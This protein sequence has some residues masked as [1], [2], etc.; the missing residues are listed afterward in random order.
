MLRSHSDA[1]VQYT[2]VSRNVVTLV[3]LVSQRKACAGRSTPFRAET[4]ERGRC[5]PL[6]SGSVTDTAVGVCVQGDDPKKDADSSDKKS[7]E[8]GDPNQRKT[9]AGSEDEGG[10]D[11]DKRDENDAGGDPSEQPPQPEEAPA[12]G[13]E[14]EMDAEEVKQQA[15]QDDH[16]QPQVS[17]FPP[18]F[19]CFF[20]FCLCL[21]LVF[22][23]LAR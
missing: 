15:A 20:L 21:F 2:H 4:R 6:G 10:Q 1:F 14:G 9:V 17:V 7:K 3:S 13:D 23:F 5:A 18:L 16:V 12:S 11:D 19:F 22:V 8:Q